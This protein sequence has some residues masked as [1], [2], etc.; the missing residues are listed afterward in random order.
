MSPATTHPLCA[1]PNVIL[2]PHNARLSKEAAIRMAIST[3]T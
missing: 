1:L 2:C 3:A